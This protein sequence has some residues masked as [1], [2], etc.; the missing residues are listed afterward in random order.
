MFR[1]L[2]HDDNKGVDEAL[3][4][5]AYGVGLVAKG[6]HWL[7][8]GDPGSKN[9]GAARLVYQ[10]FLLQISVYCFDKL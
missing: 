4:E 6:T 3:N 5:T 2:L 8:T 1:R 9:G 7:K 10:D